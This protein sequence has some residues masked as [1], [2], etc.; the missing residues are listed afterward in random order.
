[1]QGNVP[2]DGIRGYKLCGP[3]RE[4]V[5][6]GCRV[7]GSVPLSGDNVPEEMGVMTAN[8]VVRP[9]CVGWCRSV[10]RVGDMVKVRVFE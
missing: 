2:V 5:E 8:F 10:V 4:L 9:S 3:L 6:H 7:C 1:M